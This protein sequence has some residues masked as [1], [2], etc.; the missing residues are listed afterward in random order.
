MNVYERLREKIDKSIPIPM[1]ETRNG[2]EVEI[3]RRLISPDEAELACILSGQPEPVSVISERSGIPSEALQPRLEVLVKKGIIFKVYLEEPLYGLATMMPGI[4][5]F[6]VNRLTPDLV[7]LFEQYYAQGHGKA[8]LGNNTSFARVIPI[9]KS[10]EPSMNVHTYDE[11][12][13]IIDNAYAVTLA[14]CLCRTNKKLIGEG[15]DAPVEDA[16]ILLD[17]WA[18]YY[19]ENGL[20]K[21]VSKEEGKA[22]LKRAEA[23]GLVHNSLNVQDG[24]LFICNCCGCCCAL[25]RGITQLELPTAVAKSNFIAKVSTQDCTGCGECEERCQI[26]AISIGDSVSVIDEKRCIGCGVCVSGCPVDAIA[27]V[28]R[29]E[30]GVL[31]SNIN[32]LMTKIA[33]GR[34]QP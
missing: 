25:L 23:A 8:V 2:V 17:A 9:N 15:C 10:L 5:E 18:D 21:R 31:P 20:G 13:K 12:D 3:L 26:H 14:N 30:E 34:S 11:V 33:E 1:P 27:M 24:S 16:C 4:Y 7:R 32:E 28:R 29:P 6:Q 19:A 22:A